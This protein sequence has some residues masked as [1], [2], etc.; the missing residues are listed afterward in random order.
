MLRSK[1]IPLFI[2]LRPALSSLVINEP[3][4]FASLG[5]RIELEC[6]Q[7]NSIQDVSQEYGGGC[8]WTLPSGDICS[9]DN[10]CR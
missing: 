9:A 10:I 5:A 8:Q 7:I 6:Y 4:A 3:L 2:L 1:F